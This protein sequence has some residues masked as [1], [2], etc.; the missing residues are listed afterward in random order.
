MSAA[1]GGARPSASKGSLR[2][3]ARIEEATR[4]L[5]REHESTEVSVADIADLHVSETPD[6]ASVLSPACLRAGAH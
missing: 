2:R 3:L 1:S 5:L 4:Q 6:F